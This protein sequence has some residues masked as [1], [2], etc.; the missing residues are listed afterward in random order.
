MKSHLVHLHLLLH[1]AHCADVMFT[2]GVRSMPTLRAL[3]AT[4]RIFELSTIYRHKLRDELLHSYFSNISLI[5]IF[6]RH[7]TINVYKYSFLLYI[8]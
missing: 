4:K 2:A 3:R 7:K 8:I 6:I 1:T 5:F